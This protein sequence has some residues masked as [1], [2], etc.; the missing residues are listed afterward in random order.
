[1]HRGIEFYTKADLPELEEKKENQLRIFHPPAEWSPSVI[2]H[3]E[4]GGVWGRGRQLRD[5]VSMPQHSPA[6]NHK[7]TML[8]IPHTELES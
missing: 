7:Q 4:D 2:R 3:R 8:S 1:M 5:Y 6:P